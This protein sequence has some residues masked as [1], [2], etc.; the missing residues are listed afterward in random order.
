M[1]R[2][3][4]ELGRGQLTTKMAQTSRRRTEQE[5]GEIDLE[6]VPNLANLDSAVSLANRLLPHTSFSLSLLSRSARCVLYIILIAVPPLSSHLPSTVPGTLKLASLLKH[7]KNSYFAPLSPSG[8][9]TIT[10]GAN[11]ILVFGK[12]PT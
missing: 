11:L 1:A 7:H 8:N 9:F 5:A 12:E 2:L 6:L 4:R 10:S 3:I